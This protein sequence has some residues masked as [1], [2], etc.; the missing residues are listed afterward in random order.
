MRIA[1]T[2]HRQ[3]LDLN[4]IIR[5]CQAM[6]R[7][8]PILIAGTGNS[9]KITALCL[10]ASGFD[11]RLEPDAVNRPQQT[12][13]HIFGANRPRTGQH[14]LQYDWQNVLALSVSARR[15][16]ETLGVWPQLDTP[17]QPVSEMRVHHHPSG[18]NQYGLNRHASSQWG[19]LRLTDMPK[20]ATENPN[21]N[22]PNAAIAHIVSLASL[23]RAI[24]HCVEQCVSETRIARLPAAIDDFA[25][26]TARLHNGSTITFSLLIDTQR[27]ARPWRAR[28]HLTACTHDYNAAA[29]TASVRTGTAHGGIARQVFLPDG[30]LALLPLPTPHDMA[31]RDMALIWSLPTAR[32]S[33]LAATTPAHFIHELTQATGNY[34]GSVELTSPCAVQQ[35]TARVAQ[36]LTGSSVVLLGDA[37]HLVHPL[38][39]QGFNLTLRD[40]ALLADILYDGRRL[41]LPADNH[42][43]LKE[44]RQQRSA[45]AG[46]TVAATHILNRLFTTHH[47]SLR[48]LAGF[49]MA[50][51]G[52]LA[53]RIPTITRA[54]LTQ[55]NTGPGAGPDTLPRLMRGTRFGPV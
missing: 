54:F 3:Q 48:M 49:G 6:T 52:F 29:L 23:T 27:N 14:D 16:L 35:L 45:D 28:H 33:A 47:T 44:Y 5:Q 17:S 37:A 22:D 19:G 4:P 30:P 46:V 25:A 34:L 7:S 32:A 55:A 39:G 36:Q 50:M 9:G 21:I 10:A 8:H 1:G 40:A 42:T 2:T 24:D 11:I 53:T 41:G 18:L 13:E 15:M 51:T 43:L 20:P 31:A 12:P 26:H 38:A